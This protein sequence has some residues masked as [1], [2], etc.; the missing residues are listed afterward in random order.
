MQKSRKQYMVAAIRKKG[1]S[2]KHAT[3]I[4]K[5]VLTNTQPKDYL[6]DWKKSINAELAAGAKAKAETDR[7]HKQAAINI[8]SATVGKIVVIPPSKQRQCPQ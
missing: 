2:R 7:S 5:S 8:P 1:Y 3:N 6:T 4:A